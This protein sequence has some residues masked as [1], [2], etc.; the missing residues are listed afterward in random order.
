VKYLNEKLRSELTFL[1]VS[2]CSMCARRAPKQ[3]TAEDAAR[4]WTELLHN[5]QMSCAS[6][7][8]CYPGTARRAT[9]VTSLL[10]VVRTRARSVGALSFTRNIVTSCVAYALCSKQPEECSAVMIQHCMPSCTCALQNL[11]AVTDLLGMSLYAEAVSRSCSVA[12]HVTA[13][14]GNSNYVSLCV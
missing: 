5:M 6:Q 4:L 2:S 1:L 3:L 13:I 12:S 8:W 10:H 14:N 9:P 7:C 11:P